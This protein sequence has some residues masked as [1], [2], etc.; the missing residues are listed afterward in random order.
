MKQRSPVLRFVS[1]VVLVASL[2]LSACVT[3]AMWEDHDFDDMSSTAGKVALTPITLFIDLI[4][5]AIVGAL[6]SE[7]EDDC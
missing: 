6:E 2:G 7:A 1:V 5:L 4:G 3:T